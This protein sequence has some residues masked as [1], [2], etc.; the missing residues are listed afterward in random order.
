ML[1]V[2]V[3]FESE[4]EGIIKEINDL[5]ELYKNYN[6]IIGFSESIESGTHFIKVFCDDNMESRLVNKFDL[7]M[8]NIIYTIVVDEFI[9]KYLDSFL[10]DSYFFLKYEELRELK[11]ECIY[12]LKDDG[13]LI[14]DNTISYYNKK[15]SI[16]GKI[17]N[18]IKEKREI[19]I[20]G[21]LTFRMKELNDDFVFILDKIVER[22]MVEREY[23]EFIKLLKYFVEVQDPKIDEV[24]IIINK[25]GEYAFKDDKNRDIKK[26]MFSE[27]F[28]VKY[29]NVN[30]DDV[31]LSG[32]ITN[33]PK[34]IIIH[35]AENAINGEIIDTIVKVF[36][37]R[38][39]L[40]D[41]CKICKSIKSMVLSPR[42]T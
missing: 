20:K 42:R 9:K 16:V 40:C 39:Q 21:F 6:K 36:T 7:Y 37:D 18:F 17:Q 34:K 12:I 35:C 41:D 24:N 2:T 29:N 1:L 13:K 27:L 32:L 19:N 5:K 14:N 31:L 33:S 23:D 38:V 4:R 28:D 3:G 30:E 15:N 22:Y 25:N 8:A 26:E 11:K 10:T